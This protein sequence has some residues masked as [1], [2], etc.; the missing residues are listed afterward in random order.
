M[1]LL[2]ARPDHDRSGVS[3][4]QPLAQRPGH[5]CSNGLHSLPVRDVPAHQTG[6]SSCLQSRQRRCKM[7][8]ATVSRRTFIKTAAAAGGGLML[9]FYLPARGEELFETDD[10]VFTPNVWINIG[11][12][13]SV[14]ITCHRSEMGQ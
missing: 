4:R 5:R 6:N 14:A 1:R 9:S 13:G 8:T 2:P 3:A 10:K 12:D 7:K 11:T